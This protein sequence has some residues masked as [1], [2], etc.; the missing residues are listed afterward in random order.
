MRLLVAA[1]LFSVP[2]LAQE[3][4][5][6]DR[7]AVTFNEI[8]RGFH[9]SV[10]GGFWA[11]INPPAGAGSRQYFLLGQTA[12]VEVGYDFGEHVGIALF[13]MGSGNRAGS[14]YTGLSQDPISGAP[15]ASGDYSAF[16][17]GL[18][19]RI[20]LVGFKDAQDVKRSWIY[21]RAAA[22]YVIY[23]PRAL[24][25][26]SDVLVFGGPGFEYFTRLRHF[27]IGV[28]A[29]FNAHLLTASFGFAIT[30]VL[31]YAF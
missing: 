29:V 28:E 15:A 19:A 16:V 27:S 20:S 18:S 24:L 26:V 1:L 8:E 25:P 2:A 21:I 10:A 13:A 14:D 23:Q 6:K 17:P 22:G 11:T 31:R 7:E 4:V 9:L 5:L 12:R 3:K 30:P